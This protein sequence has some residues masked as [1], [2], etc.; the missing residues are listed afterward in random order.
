M[1]NN[2]KNLAEKS[3]L[4][5]E[6]K[7]LKAALDNIGKLI[8][9]LQDWTFNEELNALHETYGN[10]L[11][12]FEEGIK[13]PSRDMIYNQ[14]RLAAYEL[15]DRVY[16]ALQTKKSPLYYFER[17][18]SFSIAEKSSLA[19][20]LANIKDISEKMALNAVLEPHNEVAKQLEREMEYNAIR[21]FNHVWLSGKFSSDETSVISDIFDHKLLP[22]S[23][24]CLII[25]ALTLHLQIV[26]DEEKLLLLLDAYKNE[27]EEIRQR[28]LTGILLTLRQ[29]DRRLP[30]YPAI[31]QRLQ[32]LNEDPVFK[33][34]IRNILQQFILS[35]DTEKIT[36][37]INEEIL[38]EM[39]KIN[40]ILSKKI[41]LEDLMSGEG[42]N[43]KNPEWQHFIEEAGLNDK[44]QEFSELQMEGA[45]VMHSSFSHLKTHPFFSE[46]SNWFLLFNT[47]H[48]VFHADFKDQTTLNLLDTI[49]SS[50]F[51]CNSDKFSL[52][53]SI[54]QM[55]DTYRQIVANQFSSEATAMSEIQKS[56]LPNPDKK[57]IDIANQYIRDLYRFYKL[58]P[59]KRELVDIFDITPDFF[60]ATSIARLI[61]DKTSLQTIGEYYFTKGYY[62]QAA[63]I[64][65]QLMEFSQPDVELFQKKGYC[66]QMTGD[67][68]GALDTYLNAE[69]LNSSNKWTINK[70]AYCYRML[71]KPEDALIY[72][73]KLEQIQP[74]NLSVQLNI[75]HCYLE[76]KN[77]SEALKYYFKV[78]YLDKDGFKAWRPI[79]WC[80]FLTGKYEQANDY[81]EKI[82]VAGKAG[83]AD[84]L[85]S[86]HT[87]WAMGHIQQAIA[88]Y[89][90]SIRYPESN[91][92]HF[93]EAFHNDEPDLLRAGINTQDIPLLLDRLRYLT[94]L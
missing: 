55:P 33:K 14:L 63:A 41:K 38:P 43:D 64:F 3:Y 82:I 9:E 58:F 47:Q 42:L 70:L 56:D 13:D 87:Q 61:A 78:E 46:L 52:Y 74:D 67:L 53:L 83:S 92:Q 72:Y 7:K 34:N 30:L 19:G 81:F 62:Q 36:R 94:M 35:K 59:R 40:P 49:G 69:L 54:A 16:I 17:K 90:Q 6:Q 57:A 91:F 77:Y 85:N 76:L 32:H 65:D 84:F 20:L 28:T 89:T 37:K 79:A 86:G 66:L 11:R 68:L 31:D 44:L 51:L 73:R 8:S 93:E 21:L 2:Y 80:S 75:G 23:I 22:E 50:S 27:N 10:L 29:Y 24:C 48:S 26:W 5:L 45:D 12:Y 1:A 71:K 18:R 15:T 4:L 39:M 60:Q 88:L 25:T